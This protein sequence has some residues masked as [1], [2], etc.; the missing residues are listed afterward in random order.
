MFLILRTCEGFS[1]IQQTEWS[2]HHMTNIVLRS[3]YKDET[4]FYRQGF[5][6]LL[7]LSALCNNNKYIDEI[8]DLEQLSLFGMN[9]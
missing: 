5:Y 8:L 7:C 6:V 4:R 3:G 1:H 2:I 9:S